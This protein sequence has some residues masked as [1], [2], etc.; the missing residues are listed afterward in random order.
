MCSNT[1]LVMENKEID[2][3]IYEREYIYIKIKYI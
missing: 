3:K 2:E 1:L